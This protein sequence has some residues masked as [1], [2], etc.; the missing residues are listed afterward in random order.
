MRTTFPNAG[1]HGAG[2]TSATCSPSHPPTYPL[3]HSPSLPTRSLSHSLTFSASHSLSPLTNSLRN[4]DGFW[5]LTFNGCDAILTQEQ[6]LFYVAFLLANPGRLFE[7]LELAEKVFALYGAHQDFRQNMPWVERRLQQTQ[8]ARVLRLKQETLEAILERGGE[9]EPVKAEVLRE[10]AAIYEL[11]KAAETQI[12]VEAET[13]AEATG[14][15]ILC[16]L[17][18]LQLSLANGPV[19]KSQKADPQNP[20]RPFAVHLLRHLLIP[21]I[22]LSTR[23][24]TRFVYEPPEGV[25]WA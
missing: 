4:D 6:A 14:N 3:T 5:E 13:T 9:I 25:V 19:L 21:T 7:P 8:V 16:S 2:L 20:I 10:L 17:Y 15:V 18:R 1:R 22:R 24:G 23:G 11:Q 12:A